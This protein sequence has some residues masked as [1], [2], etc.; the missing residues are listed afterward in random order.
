MTIAKDDT[1]LWHI[2][3]HGLI[4]QPS[5]RNSATNNWRNHGE[6][7]ARNLGAY[8]GVSLGWVVRGC[9]PGTVPRRQK[10]Y[11]TRFLGHTF[12][13]RGMA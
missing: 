6:S 10:V 4:W 13:L 9:F 2:G 8:H 7:L 11:R 12:A 3:D 1:M 5:G